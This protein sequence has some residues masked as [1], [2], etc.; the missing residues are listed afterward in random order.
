[1][2]QYPLTQKRPSA[3]GL[4]FRFGISLGIRVSRACEPPAMVSRGLPGSP[5]LHSE[6]SH[7]GGHKHI[8]RITAATITSTIRC[9]MLRLVNHQRA[10]ATCLA[11]APIRTE[12]PVCPTGSAIGGDGGLVLGTRFLAPQ[13][14]HISTDPAKLSG[15]SCASLQD[16][17]FQWIMNHRAFCPR[18]RRHVSQGPKT[19]PT[20]AAF[21]MR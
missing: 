2:N 8:V 3:P 9:P 4:G 10:L 6:Y 19:I 12:S 1:M 5:P 14:G 7:Q 21:A 16:Q 13:L 20:L 11:T 15:D 17:H 18:L